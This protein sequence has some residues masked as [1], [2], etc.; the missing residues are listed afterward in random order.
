ME[1][2]NLYGS[3]P[4]EIGLLTNLTSLDVAG[5]KLQG[6][7]FTEVGNLRKL[8]VLD[9]ANNIITGPLPTELGVLANIQHLDLRNN[10]MT[11]TLPNE[12]GFAT[13]LRAVS[14]GENFWNSIIPTEYSALTKLEIFSAS[15]SNPRLHGTIPA[16]FG[17]LNR[18]SMLFLDRND[19][20]GSVPEKI[21]QL[22]NLSE[23]LTDSCAPT[24]CPP[25]LTYLL[26]VSG[27]QLEL[28]DWNSPELCGS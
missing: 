25:Y 19:L 24:P 3:L 17:E 12:L 23:Y 15:F 9:L 13:E 27:Y 5:N 21:F 4:S 22:P 16:F 1:N 28:V 2:L 14:L 20:A 7:L 18:L 11:G 8:E 10:R 26:S 6:T